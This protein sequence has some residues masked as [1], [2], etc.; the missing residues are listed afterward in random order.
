[1]QSAV[2]HGGSKSHI[3]GHR[4]SPSSRVLCRA[5]HPCDRRAYRACRVSHVYHVSC[6]HLCGLCDGR[7]AFCDRHADSFSL[8]SMKAC[9]KTIVMLSHISSPFCGRHVYHASCGHHA[10]RACDRRVSHVSCGHRVHRGDHR[11][12]RR[13]QRVR[14]AAG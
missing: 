8:L 12:Q 5:C 10:C 4:V 1:M 3:R 11:Q 2:I 13:Q 7:H 9:Q 6:G 14:I